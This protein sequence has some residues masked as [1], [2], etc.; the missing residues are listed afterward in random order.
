MAKRKKL[1]QAN[2]KRIFRRTAKGT[3]QININPKSMRGGTR[4]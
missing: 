3:K 4:L 2:D 1:P